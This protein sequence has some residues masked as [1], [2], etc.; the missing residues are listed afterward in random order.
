MNQDQTLIP[1]TLVALTPS[2]RAGGECVRNLVFMALMSHTF[3][4]HEVT[5]FE[6]SRDINLNEKI[7]TRK[8]CKG[9]ET[10]RDI[11]I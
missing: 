5:K 6:I 11:D 7:S 4:T 9:I 1:G 10:L 3:H 8:C 2:N